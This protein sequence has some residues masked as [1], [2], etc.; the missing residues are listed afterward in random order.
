MA[1]M[2]TSSMLAPKTLPTANWGLGGS[3]STA[4]MLVESSGNEVAR[5]TRILPTNKRPKPVNEARASP[6]LAK[7][8][9][10]NHTEAALAK[11]TNMAMAKSAL[12]VRGP[13]M[14]R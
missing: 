1:K 5:A 2:K 3:K 13:A 11:N 7:P 14:A 6:Y 9:P 4:E 10:R 12:I 8:I